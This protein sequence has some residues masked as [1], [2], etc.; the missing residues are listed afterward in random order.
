M[1]KHLILSMLFVLSAFVFAMAATSPFSEDPVSLQDDKVAQTPDEANI[2][3]L[4]EQNKFPMTGTIEAASRLRLRSWPWGMVLGMFESGTSMKIVGE[5][6]E[7]YKV[8]INGQT[9]FM[10]K[11]YIS[12]P[13]K[14]ASGVEP[15]YP[16]D[17]R[18]GGYLSITEGT[19]VATGKRSTS[20]GASVSPT[21]PG[22]SEAALA[23]YKGG[24]LSPAE[25]GKLFGP[26]ARENMRKTGVPASVTLAQ[27][28]LETGW[29]R[30][31]IG[32]AKNLFGI[33]G[34]GPAG[35]IRVPTQ[36]FV[37][38]RMITINDNFRKYNS[39]QESFDDHARLLQNSRYGYALQFNKNPDRYAQEI[40]K[41]GY[42]TDPNYASKL[43]SIMKANNFYQYDV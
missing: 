17:T 28:A 3:N 36:E 5:S 30:S 29:G 18:S 43:I 15:Y 10:H 42:A 37:N 8:E 9:G 24:K 38:G 35:T 13:G 25:F 40:H 22:A 14:P 26:V 4:E 6:G 11:N 34:T 19:A 31:S 1:K 23:S 39:W 20:G 16:G 27:A 32:D 41:A 33:K 21:T 2:A 12:V 7:F